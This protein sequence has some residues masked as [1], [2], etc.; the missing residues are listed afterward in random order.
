MHYAPAE[1]DPD[2]ESPAA[3]RDA[4]AGMLDG[5]RVRIG[6]AADANG[7]AASAAAVRLAGIRTPIGSMLAVAADDALLLL[8]FTDRRRLER[9]L[10]RLSRQIDTMLVP[11]ENE[12]TRRTAREL[13]E[14]FA[15]TRHAFT[16]PLR[17]MGSEFQRSAWDALL[18]IPYGETRSY[19]EQ[20][21][22]LDPPAVPRA[23]GRANGD[24][25]IAVIVPCH[26][27]VGSDGSLTGYGGGLWRKRWL[28]DHELRHRPAAEGEFAFGAPAATR[29]PEPG[30]I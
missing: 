16:V 5:I 25:P 20:A 19:G 17:P 14:Y 3:L 12:M 9:Q 24:N 8:E 26:R 21:R 29:M 27:V 18:R 10:R 28:L 1:R 30:T 23:V 2:F 4:I 7:S 11:G 15:G 13:D 6:A 22:L